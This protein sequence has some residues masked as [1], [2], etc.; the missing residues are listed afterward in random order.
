[1]NSRG[2]S[3]NALGAPSLARSSVVLVS[4]P[5]G[6]AADVVARERTAQSGMPSDFSWSTHAAARSGV[7]SPSLSSS[8]AIPRNLP[9]TSLLD[10]ACSYP[11]ESTYPIIF[12]PASLNAPCISSMA[13]QKLSPYHYNHHNHYNH[14]NNDNLYNHYNH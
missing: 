7:M 6:L 12:A 9:S 3:Q 13:S 11:E 10:S 8:K 4:P 2:P 1:M 14:Y 5:F